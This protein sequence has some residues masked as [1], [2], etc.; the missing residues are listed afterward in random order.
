[1]IRSSD[2]WKN[3]N[4]GAYNENDFVIIK[5]FGLTCMVIQHEEGLFFYRFMEEINELKLL[6]KLKL[7]N[8]VDGDRSRF[9]KFMYCERSQRTF[10]VYIFK[11][12]KT[13]FRW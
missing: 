3:R 10:L 2:E 11:M 8:F 5:S 6:K 13:K 4:F 7:L 9:R 12:L 1:M